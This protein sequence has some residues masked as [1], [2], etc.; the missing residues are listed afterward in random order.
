MEKVEFFKQIFGDN[1]LEVREFNDLFPVLILK[2]SNPLELES[3]VTEKKKYKSFYKFLPIFLNSEFIQ[4]AKDTFAADILYIKDF[5]KNL[6]GKDNFKDIDLDNNFLRL[7]IERELRSKL[8]VI[9]SSSYSIFSKSE[10]TR[11]SQDLLYSLRYAIY[12]FSKLKN[13]NFSFKNEIDL[14]ISLC[15]LLNYP[16]ADKITE[17]INGKEDYTHIQRFSLLYDCLKFLISKIE[18]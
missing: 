13:L 18:I 15:N 1:L 10:I 11:F 12:A 8:F 5:S 14:F 9:A 16:D 17:I 3:F 2:D 6:Y 4:N 7:N